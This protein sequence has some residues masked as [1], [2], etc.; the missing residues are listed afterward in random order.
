MGGSGSTASIEQ[1]HT[2]GALMVTNDMTLLRSTEPVCHTVAC[3]WQLDR[4]QMVR[5]TGLVS[6]SVACSP[7]PSGAHHCDSQ[8]QRGCDT[9]AATW[10]HLALVSSTATKTTA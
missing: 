2:G 3:T 4:H 10:H 8:L 9:R 7:E 6:H 5:N 1:P